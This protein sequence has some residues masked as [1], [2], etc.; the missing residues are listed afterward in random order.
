MSE[1]ILHLAP[2]LTHLNFYGLFDSEDDEEMLQHG[3]RLLHALSSIT[4]QTL[5][6]LNLSN[7]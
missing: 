3:E 2:P 4:Y 5:L 7:N 1:K 6:S